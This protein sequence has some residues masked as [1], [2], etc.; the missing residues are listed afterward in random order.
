MWTACALCHSIA[1]FLH[2]TTCTCTCATC[3]HVFTARKHTPGRPEQRE[4]LGFWIFNGDSTW[5]HLVRYSYIHVL[6]WHS[7]TWLCKGHW[8]QGTYLTRHLFVVQATHLDMLSKLCPKWGHP[9]KLICGTFLG[10]ICIH[11]YIGMCITH[12]W[13]EGGGGSP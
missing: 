10:L 1:P 12:P 7:G 2:V 11:S 4:G 8:K 5:R 13:K 3:M 6:T 9:F